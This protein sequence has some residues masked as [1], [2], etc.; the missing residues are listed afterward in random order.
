[1]DEDK[2]LDLV[3][4]PEAEWRSLRTAVEYV[5]HHPDHPPAPLIAE[6]FPDGMPSEDA[7][8][9]LTNRRKIVARRSGRKR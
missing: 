6:H 7:W 5:L 9:N 1:M 8:R 4:L 2:M 3:S